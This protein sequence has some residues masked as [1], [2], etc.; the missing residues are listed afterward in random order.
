[1]KQWISECLSDA[2][3]VA[4]VLILVVIPTGLLLFHVWN[5]YRIT[6]LGY[7]V[8]EVTSEH[9][10]LLEENKKLV[11]EARLQGHSDRVSEVAK[12]QFGLQEAHPEQ[13]VTIDLTSDVVP[14]AEHAHLDEHAR[15]EGI[16]DSY[17]SSLVAVE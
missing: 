9:R 13:F 4:K 5:Q 6:E 7:Q 2:T 8:A 10:T 1:M 12:S 16:E 15:L 14:D 11:V 3:I 17:G